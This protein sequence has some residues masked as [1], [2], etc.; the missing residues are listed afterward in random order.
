MPRGRPKSAIPKTPGAEMQPLAGLPACPRWLG[1]IAKQV[2]KELVR[3]LDAAGVLTQADRNHMA[4]YC[5][6]CER[7]QKA[8]AKMK[9]KDLV[10]KGKHG[11]GQNPYLA[12]ANR[13]M[14]QMEHFGAKLG[15]NPAD[16]KR[17]KVEVGPKPADGDPKA[18]F[19][20]F[21]EG[22]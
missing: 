9:A 19:F 2:W 6:A 8:E 15:L 7:W 18:R 14:E 3:V 13:A 16:R 1:R 17:I 4:M 20:K 10:L 5:V 22:A 21:R 12:I 11:A